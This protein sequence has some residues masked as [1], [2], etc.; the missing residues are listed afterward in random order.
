MHRRSDTT[1]DDFTSRLV[2]FTA[3]LVF[4]Y[5]HVSPSSLKILKIGTDVKLNEARGFYV[6]T[7]NIFDE[8]TWSE[9]I[10]FDSLGIDQDVSRV[11]RITLLI[12]RCSSTTMIESI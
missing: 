8:T 11:I 6:S 2:V 10:Y 1:R 9:P 7:D 5:V 3:V 4:W 12:A